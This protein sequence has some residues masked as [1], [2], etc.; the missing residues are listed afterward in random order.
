MK[1]PL[2]TIGIIAATLAG[3]QGQVLLDQDFSSSG[4]LSTYVSSA[5]DSGQWNAI[6][7]SGPGVTVSVAANNLAFTRSLANVGSFSR[8]ADFTPVP[9]T[10]IYRFDLSVSGNTAA[11]TSAAVWQVGSGFGTANSAET[12]ANTYARFALNLT[13]TD[14]TFQIRDIQTLAN[15][16]DLSGTQSLMWVLNNSGAAFSYTSPLGTTS[17]VADDTADIWAGTA[18]LFSNVAVTTPTQTLADLKF[19]LSDGSGTVTM[20]NFQISIP[21]P[22]ICLLVGIGIYFGLWNVRRKRR[23][24]R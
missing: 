22:R 21:E 4:V 15:S 23:S 1:N 24:G 11:A 2:A 6:G 9:N 14:G 13:A 18:L 12:N 3:A 7:S 10:M 8:T 17:T 16:G 20:D 5:P 19:A